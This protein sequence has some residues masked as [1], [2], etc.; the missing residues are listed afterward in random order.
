MALAWKHLVFAQSYLET[1]NITKSALTAGYSDASAYSAGQRILKRDDV[2][3]YINARRTAKTLVRQQQIEEVDRMVYNLATV[4]PA[5]MFTE[6]GEIK[7]I[8]KL[9]EELQ[10]AIRHYKVR[11]TYDR[12]GNHVGTTRELAITDKLKA[13]ELFYKRQGVYND[14]INNTNQIGQINLT[15]V[16]PNDQLQQLAQ[17]E[18]AFVQQLLEQQQE[19]NEVIDADFYTV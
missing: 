15:I 8:S 9:P 17:E 2:Q 12:D 18:G 7:P 10:H 14:T 16:K 11:D 6:S 3:Q 5:E 13:V 1:D 4:N 19:S